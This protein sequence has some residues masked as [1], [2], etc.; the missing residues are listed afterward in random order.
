[1]SNLKVIQADITTLK[2]DAVVNAANKTL[3]G[4]LG[5]D[6]AIHQ[7]AGPQLLEECR[8]LHGCET[9]QA[10][11]TKGYNLPAKFVI[12]TVGPIYSGAT[13]DN[14]LLNDCYINSLE[15]AKKNG[16]HSIA[17]PAISTGAYGFPMEKAAKI[18]FATVRK[19]LES[20][21]SYD[22][23]VLMCAFDKKT[24]ELYHNE[25]IK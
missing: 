8:Q 19:W 22:I 10:K 21:S 3:L 17:F 6:G 1:M 7:A 12:H 5:V 23:E 25:L 20:N 18:A 24:L 16:L 14:N 4:G 11:L 2:V 15:L 13:N 9:G